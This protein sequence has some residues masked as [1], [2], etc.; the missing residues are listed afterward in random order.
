[1]I[2][3][4]SSKVFLA[5]ETVPMVSDHMII[6]S[7]LSKGHYLLHLSKDGDGNFKLQSHCENNNNTGMCESINT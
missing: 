6:S 3:V 1:M 5:E 4:D 2:I 7:F